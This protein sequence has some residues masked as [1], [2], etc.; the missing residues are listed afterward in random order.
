[1]GFEQTFGALP[2]V[3]HGDANRP[4]F[5]RGLGNSS[6]V[7]NPGK[8][9]GLFPAALLRTLSL[10]G[11]ERFRFAPPPE[12]FRCVG[13]EKKAVHVFCRLAPV[14]PGKQR[15]AEPFR[16]F[17]AFAKRA[18]DETDLNPACPEKPR[19]LLSHGAGATRERAPGAS[20]DVP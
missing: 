14:L 6:E 5:R 12:R 7:E 9:K 19:R 20:E 16:H 13:A 10:S 3:V 4:A 1:V 2:K 15:K 17:L 8:R 18:V 11:A